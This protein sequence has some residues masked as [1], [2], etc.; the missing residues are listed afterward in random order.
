MGRPR[1]ATKVLQMRG[2]FAKHPERKRSREHEPDVKEP[3]G[4]PP[5]MMNREEL[6]RWQDLRAWGWWLTVADRPTVEI[7][8]R[9]WTRFQMGDMKL[10]VPLLAAMAKLGMNPTD[11]SRV[12]AGGKPG[13]GSRDPAETYFG[14]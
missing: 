11:R 7:A 4:D 5:P 9:L 14:S 2:S 1:T 8:V 13:E 6:A 10:A 12:K 3:L